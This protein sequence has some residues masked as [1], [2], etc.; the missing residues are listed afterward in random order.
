MKR[1][2]ELRIWKASVDPIDDTRN[3][4]I[5]IFGRWRVAMWTYSNDEIK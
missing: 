1:I 4:A 3:I 2:L 5:Y